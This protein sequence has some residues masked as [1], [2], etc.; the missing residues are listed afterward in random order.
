MSEILF[1]EINDYIDSMLPERDHILQE[2]EDYAEK[3]SFP[4]VGP[5]VG[6]ILYQLVTL[7]KPRAVFEL[8]SGYGYSAYWFCLA[9]AQVRVHCTE[10]SSENIRM[11]EN[12]FS[13]AS[14]QNQVTFHQGLA[15]EILKGMGGKY[16]I[17]FMDVDKQQYPK[18]FHLAL[19]HLADGGLLIT[20]N[21]L[22]HGR[23]IDTSADDPS[24]HGVREYNRLI[25]NTP[26]I[27]STI[28]PVRDGVAVSL[29]M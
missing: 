5:Q 18:T 15:Q 9:N 17:I 16:D 13:L 19:A 14:R 11:A 25:F 26:G 24:T 8:G 2:M 29:K 28:I 12:W 3:H 10:K 6:R 7:K 20:D 21:V 23:V 1:P 4:I 27:Y 22:W